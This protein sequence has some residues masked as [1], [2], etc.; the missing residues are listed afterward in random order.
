MI[1]FVALKVY[2]FPFIRLVWIGT[3]IMMVGFVMSMVR[4][5][6][7]LRNARVSS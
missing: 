7:L 5:M 4:R 6:K 2:Q 1:P 3:A